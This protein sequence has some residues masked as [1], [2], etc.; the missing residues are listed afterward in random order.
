MTHPVKLEASP[1]PNGR[2]LNPIAAE[3]W[4]VAFWARFTNRRSWKGLRRKTKGSYMFIRVGRHKLPLI[5][6]L[7]AIISD[8]VG[9]GDINKDV[10]APEIQVKEQNDVFSEGFAL[11]C[12]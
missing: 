9:N 10:P 6:I 4:H 1:R 12:R 7:C 8:G 11:K 3:G 5:R 2:N